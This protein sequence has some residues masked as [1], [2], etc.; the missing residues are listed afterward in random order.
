ML[1]EIKELGVVRINCVT[2]KQKL[3][4]YP[5]Y[6]LDMLRKYMPGT[7]KDRFQSH[8][9]WLSTQI[10]KVKEHPEDVNQYVKLLK[11]LEFIEIHYGDIKEGVI[12]NTMLHQIVDG[13][14]TGN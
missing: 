10:K 8:Q 6:C 7:L 2:I 1:P 4:P 3:T 11:A 12:L 9:D 14:F 5:K 13:L